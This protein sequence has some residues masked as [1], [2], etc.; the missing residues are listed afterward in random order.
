LN[1]CMMKKFFLTIDNDYNLL[2]HLLNN[3]KIIKSENNSKVSG[4]QY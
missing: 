2:M 3:R 1:R 4:A